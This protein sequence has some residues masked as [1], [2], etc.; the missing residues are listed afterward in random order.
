MPAGPPAVA[1]CVARRDLAAGGGRVETADVP[2]LLR[3]TRAAAPVLRILR[4]RVSGIEL[5]APRSSIAVR[6]VREGEGRSVTMKMILKGTVRSW[7]ERE[8]AERAAWAA[9]GVTAVDS[10]ITISFCR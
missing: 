1:R 4:V 5:E 2:G 6:G 7:A 9:P 10:W 8:E 3:G